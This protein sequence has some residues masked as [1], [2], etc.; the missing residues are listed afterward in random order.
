MLYFDSVISLIPESIMAV[1]SGLHHDF[2][3][4]HGERIIFSSL[5]YWF[6]LTSSPSF[7]LP[8]VSSAPSPTR[9]W[10][11]G[12]EGFSRDFGCGQPRRWLMLLSQVKTSS[13][14][15]MQNDDRP[16]PRQRNQREPDQ[17]AEERAMCN[18]RVFNW[19]WRW[20]P[21]LGAPSARARWTTRLLFSSVVFSFPKIVK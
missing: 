20:A 17:T 9:A 14:P 4:W 6:L 11:A 12:G 8:A 2:P 16:G 19:A 1:N 21:R 7:P 18:W 5:F 13:L 3:L 10:R 15:A